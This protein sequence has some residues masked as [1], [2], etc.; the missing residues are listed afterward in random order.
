MKYTF[1]DNDRFDP[2]GMRES[3]SR[4]G[5]RTTTMARINRAMG[6]NGGFKGKTRFSERR[7]IEHDPE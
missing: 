6:Y 4:G 2:E 5:K 7:P 3:R 1:K